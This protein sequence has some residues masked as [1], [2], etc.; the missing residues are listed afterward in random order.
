MSKKPRKPRLPKKPSG[1]TLLDTF[2]KAIEQTKEKLQKE[3]SNNE[4]IKLL[5]ATEKTAN[6]IKIGDLTVKITAVDF[7]HTTKNCY[8]LL[9]RHGMAVC[10]DLW[11][12]ESALLVTKLR[13]FK[14]PSNI[15][16]IQ[17]ILREDTRYFNHML[18]AEMFASKL[19]KCRDSFRADLFEARFAQSVGKMHQSRQHIK[20]MV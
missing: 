19:K 5:L 13:M 4:L 14:R 20:K 12:F 7:G 17:C 16:T 6:G 3:S 9:D 1:K 18:D 2:S 11:L 10:Q 15:V 8:T